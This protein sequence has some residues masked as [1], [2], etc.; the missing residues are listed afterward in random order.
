[1]D[2]GP[3]GSSQTLIES[4]DIL[5]RHL[6]AQIAA[7]T[8]FTRLTLSTAASEALSDDGC[9]RTAGVAHVGRG[10]IGLALSLTQ[11]ES[12]P[13]VSNGALTHR[14]PTEHIVPPMPFL[15]SFARC[16]GHDRN[17]SHW[18]DQGSGS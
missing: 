10:V 12:H 4:H 17:P 18:L 13:A 6:G 2:S 3:H 16:Q 14:N 1:M 15:P 5:T 8:R 9:I 7:N 11:W